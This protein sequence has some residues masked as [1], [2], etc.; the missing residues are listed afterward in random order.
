MLCRHGGLPFHVTALHPDHCTP[1]VRPAL[2]VLPTREFGRVAAAYYPA[3]IPPSHSQEHH[4]NTNNGR[5]TS[6]GQSQEEASSVCNIVV[7]V[8]EADE[9]NDGDICGKYDDCD[10]CEGSLLPTSGSA[11]AVGA[12]EAE[13]LQSLLATLRMPP[14]TVLIRLREVDDRREFDPPTCATCAQERDERLRKATHY[15]MGTGILSVNTHIKLNKRGNKLLTETETFSGLDHTHT[16]QA[17]AE[18]LSTRLL[19]RHGLLVEPGSIVLCKG[20]QLLSDASV[21][22]S[23]AG[24]ASGDSLTATAT[25]IPVKIEAHHADGL[26][27]SSDPATVVQHG[28]A[29]RAEEAQTTFMNTRLTGLMPSSVS[30]L[31]SSSAAAVVECAVCTYHNPPGSKRCDMC[32]TAL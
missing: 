1:L 25:D 4:N 24:L 27:R 10:D 16:L 12:A 23:A 29:Q 31:D 13:E 8:L 6:K 20:K 18:K 22:L 30:T 7:D 19:E 11:A 9:Q 5:Q 3:R 2:T 21:T 26:F 15:Y 17:V 28:S 32:D 14:E